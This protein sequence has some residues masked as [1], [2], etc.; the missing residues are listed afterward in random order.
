MGQDGRM[1]AAD[2]LTSLADALA[3]RA[4]RRAG[5]AATVGGFLLGALALVFLVLAQGRLDE[6]SLPQ[7]FI[8]GTGQVAGLVLGAHCQ[9]SAR[10]LA[11]ERG[12]GQ[13]RSLAAAAVVRRTLVTVLLVAG[14]VAVWS[15]VT[16]RPFTAAALSVAIGL[17]LL[18]QF[19]VLMVVQRRGLLRAGPRPA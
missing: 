13:Q 14:T 9:L 8:L 12:A 11:A 3:D 6:S 7:V 1:D 2:E 10:A 16:M 15:L 18:S 19:V 5:T 17:A 4:L